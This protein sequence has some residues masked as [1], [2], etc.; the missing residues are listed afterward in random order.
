M[1]GYLGGLRSFRFE[2]TT[3]DEKFASDGQKIQELRESRVAVKRPNE[4]RVDRVGPAGRTVFVYDGKNFGLHA[5]DKNVYASMP[6]PAQLDAAIDEA[7]DR[8]RTDA[9]GADLLM[10]NSYRELIDGTV[11]G[12]YVGLEPVSGTMAHHLAFT[13]KDL[14]WQ[15]WIQD[16][17]QPVPLRY[18]ITSKDMPGSPQFTLEVR[19]WQPNAPLPDQLFAFTPPAGARRIEFGSSPHAGQG[20][21]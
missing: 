16:G 12:R 19:N 11:T 15:M 6:A 2:S 7:R 18:V 8:L 13:R 9:P 1:S 17:P 21:K 4:L 3:I 20:G 10:A 5:L 14:D